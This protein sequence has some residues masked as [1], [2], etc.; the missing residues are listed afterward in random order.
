MTTMNINGRHF[1]SRTAAVSGSMVLEFSL[2]PSRA[3]AAAVAAHPWYRGGSNNPEI[4]AWLTIAPDDTVTIRVAQSEIGTGVFTACPMMIA[5]EL[6]CVV[7]AE[8]ASANR[9][10]REKA[11]T[12]TL[13]VPG[14]GQYD[15]AG[16]GEPVQLKGEDGVYRHMGIGSSGAVRESRYYL[17]HGRCRGARAPAPCGCPGVG[18]L[19]C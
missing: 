12:W 15:P 3:K 2:P 14:D 8:Y 11:P 1:L 17:P 6:Q 9:N 10:A 4:N 5:E 7:R 18:R 19:G 16:G 13:P